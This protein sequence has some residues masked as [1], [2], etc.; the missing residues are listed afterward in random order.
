M[1][2]IGGDEFV[3]IC[4]GT[5]GDRAKRLQ[6][7]LYRRSA[8]RVMT[9]EDGGG[10]HARRMPLEKSVRAWPGPRRPLSRGGGGCRRW[11]TGA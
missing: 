1:A 7:R 5:H 3:V 9:F 4:L 6:E 10:K 11:R 8:A 2:R